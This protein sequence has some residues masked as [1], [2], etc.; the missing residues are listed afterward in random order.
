VLSVFFGAGVVGLSYIQANAAEGAAGLHALIFGQ[1]AA[2]QPADVALMAAIAGTA[3]A[4]TLL[5]LKELALVCFNDAFA[6]VDGWPVGL[7]DAA[8]MLLVVLATI[9]GLQAVGLILVVALQIIPPV[10]ARFWTERLWLLVVISGA[11]GAASGYIG[12]VISALLPRQPAGAVI[13]LTSGAIFAVSLIAAPN[14]GIIAASLRRLRLRLRIAGDHLLE[15]AHELGVSTLPRA[16]VALLAR[17]RGWPMPLRVVVVGWLRRRGMLAQAGGGGLRVTQAGR[18][19]GARVRR[20]HALWAQYLI[21]RAEVAPSHVDWS[22]DQVEHVL[23]ESLVRELE[24]ELAL[25]GI[26]VRHCTAGPS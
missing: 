1:A 10:A 2:M 6:R 5:L 8:M 16:E 26:D 3:I 20:N 19:R 4:A 25:R 9:A 22:V 11:I 17:T 7:I 15:R 14:R 23:S 12:S 13:V 18:E 24:G 21:S